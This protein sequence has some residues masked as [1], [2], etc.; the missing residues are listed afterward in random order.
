VFI[1]RHF[2]LPLALFNTVVEDVVVKF[3]PTNLPLI[4]VAFIKLGA[5]IL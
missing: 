1:F 2:P 4:V 3:A 5:A